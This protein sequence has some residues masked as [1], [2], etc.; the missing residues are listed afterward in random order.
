[1]T[2]SYAFIWNGFTYAWDAQ[3]HRLSVFGS[4]FGPV[5]LRGSAIE[6]EHEFA[7][8]IGAF[9]ADEARFEV[10]FMAVRTGDVFIGMGTTPVVRLS[11][12]IETSSN[13]T[14]TIRVGVKELRA[15]FTDM[16]SVNKTDM[17]RVKVLLNGFHL[18]AKS[19]HVG[20]HFG[21]LALSVY[22]AKWKSNDEIQ[23][24]LY[25]YVRP[26]FSPE[27]AH[28]G[29]DDW[30]PA[31]D[32]IY[33][34]VVDY[35]IVAGAPENVAFVDRTEE[36]N[37]DNVVEASL[38]TPR[39]VGIRITEERFQYHEAFLGMYGFEF[40]VSS[41]S[42]NRTP[43]TGRYIR[44]LAAHVREFSW[45]EAKQLGSFERA[46]E[47]SNDAALPVTWSL[48]AQHHSALIGVNGSF[49]RRQQIVK[50]RIADN[51]VITKQTVR[52]FD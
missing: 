43:D 14:N 10:P 34:V 51:C 5:H 40:Y 29:Y 50:G 15:H 18:E 49:S 2:S 39:T 48:K 26:A 9:P 36:L 31:E 19:A 35:A 23:F 12:K 42:K 47:F 28:H 17:S 21:G 7:L 38:R 8:K 46:L 4:R 24:S 44:R 52:A 33:D 22:G 37:E 11:S 6:A 1:M 16:A 20:W 45:Q 27:P 32:C 3:P 13:R 30:T 41:A 25:T